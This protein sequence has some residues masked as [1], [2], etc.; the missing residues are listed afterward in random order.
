MLTDGKW[1]GFCAAELLKLFFVDDTFEGAGDFVPRF[2][3]G[4][5]GLRDA[6]GSTVVVG[7][8]EP[9]RDVVRACGILR[10]SVCYAPP[11][12]LFFSKLLIANF[13]FRIDSYF[14]KMGSSAVF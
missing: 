3:V 8:D 6:E 13:F 14:S 7:I 4:K 2:F 12:H 10:Y 9:R 1:K 11:K 5:E